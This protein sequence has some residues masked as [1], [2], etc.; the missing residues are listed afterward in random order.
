MIISFLSF[1]VLGIVTALGRLF[2]DLKEAEEA[3]EEERQRKLLE[4]RM[5]ENGSVPDESKDRKIS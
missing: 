1:I 3:K 2:C 5:R 4:I